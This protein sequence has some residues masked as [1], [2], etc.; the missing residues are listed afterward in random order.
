MN[1]LFNI[2]LLFLVA[3][4]FTSFNTFADEPVDE[5]VVEVSHIDTAGN[6]GSHLAYRSDLVFISINQLARIAMLKESKTIRNEMIKGEGILR[7]GAEK[8]TVDIFSARKWLNDTKRKYTFY[9]LVEIDK[10][11]DEN[12]TLEILREIRHQLRAEDAVNRA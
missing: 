11:C 12:I 6:E 2:S 3:F 1:K 8:D 9:D 10:L 5:E 4:T 7:Y